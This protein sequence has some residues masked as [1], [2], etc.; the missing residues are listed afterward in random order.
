MYVMYI[1][2]RTIIIYVIYILCKELQQADTSVLWFSVHVCAC[3]CVC[4]R[5][6]VSV[7]VSVCVRVRARA[8]AGR[9]GV[10]Q[11]LNVLSVDRYVHLHARART[12]THSQ[13][14]LT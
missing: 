2:S 13:T 10:W 5:V 6:C 7:C 9:S 8:V 14:P 12:H 1:I 11:S 4:A 3:L